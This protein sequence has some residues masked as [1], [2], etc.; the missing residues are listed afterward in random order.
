MTDTS[1]DAQAPPEQAFE[2]TLTNYNGDHRPMWVSNLGGGQ[3]ALS[4]I[5][6]GEREIV[7][8]VSF[9]AGGATSPVRWNR[10]ATM[11]FE[12][13]RRDMWEGQIYGAI[14]QWRR[15]AS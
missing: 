5:V 6:E 4:M 7:A 10:T 1:V 12:Q 11:A 9:G 14:V 8:L 2:I 13:F 3:A 15:G